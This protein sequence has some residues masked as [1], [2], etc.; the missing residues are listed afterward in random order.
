MF[1]SVFAVVAGIVTLTVASFAIEGAV[2][3]LVNAPVVNQQLWFRMLTMGYTLACVAAGGYVAAWLARRMEV[4]H[5]VVMGAVEAMFTIGAMI[6]LRE[7]QPLWT[8][9]AGIALIVPAAW[10]GGMIRAKLRS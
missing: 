9:T 6:Q 2:G 8:W 10:L 4:R 3:L 7:S 5:A 1:R